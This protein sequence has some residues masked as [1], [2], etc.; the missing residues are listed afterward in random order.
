MTRPF[1]SVTVFR[2]L[3]ASSIFI[4]SLLVL[5]GCFLL[6]LFPPQ[7]D[8]I[9]V[10]DGSFVEGDRPYF[11]AG[12]N[13]WYGPYLAADDTGGGRARLRRE[14]DTLAADGMTNLRIL[15]LSEHSRIRWALSPSMVEAPGMLNERLLIGLDI[16]LDEMSRRGMRA[17][18]F[19]TNYWE[20]SGGMTSYLDWSD[21][22]TF[23]D[24]DSAGWDAY[25]DYAG[26]FGAHAEAQ[27]M[28]RGH[29][30]QL[31]TRT[32]TVN[33]RRYADDPTI[34]A[35]QLANEPRPGTVSARGDS[36]LPAF[37]A[38]VDSTARFIKTLDSLH[39]VSTGSEGVI[40]SLVSE[41]NYARIHSSPAIDYLTF[42]LWPVVWQWYD[43]KRP[44]ETSVAADSLSLAYIHQ[45]IALARRLGKPVV[46]EEFGM[47]RDTGGFDPAVPTTVRDRWYARMF[48]MIE[49]SAAAGAPMAGSNVW[50]WGG[51]G[52]G[53]GS[54][55]RYTPGDGFTG[56]PPHEPQGFNSVF[57]T[58]T[59]TRLIL[60]EHARRL[61]SL[62]FAPILVE[63]R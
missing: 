2:D 42:H 22:G 23:V 56:D 61:R 59:S 40:G 9:R 20:W 26:S 33:G 54:T 38:W 19:L 29:V 3:R 21:S 50:A 46:M 49:D 10:R 12:V 45:H 4:L 5:P 53:N 47:S 7:P 37:V 16:M 63:R 36:M 32:N 51:E 57:T 60:R 39:L 55:Y 27:Q 31:V 34:M 14:L 43:P 28:F 48:R 30:R 58:D 1:I 52:R 24:P 6:G 8:F 13:L 25:M 44:D 62:L 18:V 41:E 35:W 15:G 17:V 11:V